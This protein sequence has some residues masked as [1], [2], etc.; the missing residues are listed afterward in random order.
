MLQPKLAKSNKESFSTTAEG[1]REEAEKNK[2]R[3][4]N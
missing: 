4:Y 1:R 2:N 3:A